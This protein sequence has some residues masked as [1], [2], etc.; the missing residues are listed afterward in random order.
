MI[1]VLPEIHTMEK[2]DLFKP[3][4]ILNLILCLCFRTSYVLHS[5]SLLIGQKICFEYLVPIKKEGRQ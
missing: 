1:K 5:H 3:I 2:C 4:L